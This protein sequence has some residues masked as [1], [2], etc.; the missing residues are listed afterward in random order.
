M[1]VRKMK[2]LVKIV[3]YVGLA[4]ILAPASVFAWEVFNLRNDGSLTITIQRRKQN[5]HNSE[6]GETSKLR[7]SYIEFSRTRRV[8]LTKLD[9]NLA[10]AVLPPPKKINFVLDDGS[11]L[12]PLPAEMQERL[13]SYLWRFRK[14]PHFDC[15]CF[16]GLVAFGERCEQYPWTYQFNESRA[17]ELRPG[18]LLAVGFY[19]AKGAR[20]KL[21]HSL[22]FLGAQT[23]ETNWTISKFGTSGPL[24][25]TSLAEAQKFYRSPE[26]FELKGLAIK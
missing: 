7:L 26:V 13:A 11:V 21:T 17:T 18:Q 14:V 3:G 2:R 25:V 20:S 19:P 12:P 9:F 1:R 5:I 23:M 4:L 22:I 16:V 24:G 15:H 8:E 6:T 10:R